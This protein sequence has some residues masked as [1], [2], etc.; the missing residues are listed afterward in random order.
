M[1]Y[2]LTLTKSERAAFDWVGPR[3]CACEVAGLLACEG[4]WD[5]EDADWD[6]PGDITFNM[7]EHVAWRIRELAEE[8]DFLWPCFASE[9]TNKLNAFC[10]SIL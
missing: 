9:L 2:H 5:P 1:A 7:P 6:D 3:Y 10:F 8:E 4:R